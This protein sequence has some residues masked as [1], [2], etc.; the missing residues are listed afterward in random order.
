MKAKWGHLHQGLDCTSV[1]FSLGSLLES[2]ASVRF[3]IKLIREESQQ[4]PPVVLPTSS[5]FYLF[6]YTSRQDIR[7]A[8]SLYVSLRLG[9]LA[10]NSSQGWRRGDVCVRHKVL[11]MDGGL[12]KLVPSL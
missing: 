6:E 12:R 8:T 5:V 2:L 1:A 11:P 3:G 4:D 7:V 10:D 9:C